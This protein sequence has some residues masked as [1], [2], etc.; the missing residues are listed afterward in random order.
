MKAGVI[1][2]AAIVVAGASTIAVS[3]APQSSGAPAAPD[4]AN[5]TG[6]VTANPT[7]DIRSTRY[8]FDP[9]ARTNWHRHGRGQV[10]IVE[11][12][13]LRVQERGKPGREFGPRDTYSVDAG[14]V[15][16]HGARP[17]APLTQLAISFGTT[18]WLEKVTD[19]EYASAASK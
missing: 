3:Q 4:P 10:I 9:G 2:L 12:G 17:E 8:T 7:S 11:Q 19:Q 18:T 1:L 16:W 14:I 5:I 13:R 15:H 6:R